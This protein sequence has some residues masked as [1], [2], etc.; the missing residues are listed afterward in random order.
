MKISQLVALS[1]ML[2]CS[3]EAVTVTSGL[4]N[5]SAPPDDPGWANVGYHS[6]SATAVYLGNR[7]VITAFHAGGGS[8]T[9]N[10]VTYPQSGPGYQLTNN[11][12]GG[13]SA[14][15][16]LLMYQLASDPGLP[17][18]VV[19][20]SMPGVGSAVTMIGA[21]IDAN[22]ALTYWNV[23]P[24]A[25]SGND[26]WSEVSAMDPHNATGYKSDATSRTMR[27]GNNNVQ[28][29]NFYVND[30]VG[31]IVSTLTRF[32]SDPLKPNEAQALVG[33]SGGGV[34]SKVGGQWQLSGITFAIDDGQTGFD[35]QPGNTAVYRN[36]TF[37]ADLSF[38]RNQINTLMQI[39]EPSAAAG[40]V[41]AGTLLG[42]QR[43][44]RRA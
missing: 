26:I 8:V 39:P 11:G 12:A 16:D 27:W 37:M 17:S 42:L 2:A 34:F 22:P 40:V 7:W 23:V 24:V 25:G 19:S 44:R 9:L 4:G 32:D 6:N 43:R 5:T 41:V 1:L 30:G 28:Q 29:N 3:A 33:D 35:G 10:G 13:L 15:T 21:G 36:Y 18:L 14:N 20:P 38:Y 31:D